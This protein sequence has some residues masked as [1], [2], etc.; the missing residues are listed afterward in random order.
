MLSKQGSD[1]LEFSYSHAGQRTW[2]EGWW[3]HYDPTTDYLD[4]LECGMTPP[5][6]S[7]HFVAPFI[8][9]IFDTVVKK[10]R[11]DIFSEIKNH[12]GMEL[13]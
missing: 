4:H 8:Q 1:G 9:E 2:V 3:G 11:M 6:N 13:E 5:V 7:Q 12:T 10:R